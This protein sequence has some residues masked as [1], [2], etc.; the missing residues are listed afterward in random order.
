MLLKS[1]LLCAFAF[2]STVL[3]AFGVTSTSSSFVVD[4]G[5][6]NPLVITVSKSNCDITSIKYRGE[7]F[8]YSNQGSHIGSGLGSASVSSSIVSLNIAKITCTTSTLTHYYVV[9]SG[10]ATVYMATYITTEPSVG[11]LRY[12]AR[13][14][15]SKLPLEYP[16]G[17]VSTTRDSSST[18]EGSDVFVVNGQT[19]SKFYSSERFIDDNTHCVYRDNDAINVCMLIPPQSYESSSGG[20]FFRDINTNNGGDMTALYFYMNSGH[21]QTESYR[22]GL[23]GPYAMSFSRSGRPNGKTLDT[24]FFSSLGISGYVANSARGTVKGTASGVGSG[25]QGVVHWYN[26]N[27]QYWA[28]TSGNSFTSPFMKPGQYTQVLYQGEYKIASKSVSVSAGTTVTSDISASNES[29]NTILQI[30]EWDGQPK[31]FRNADKQLR[32]HP[33]DSHMSSWGPLTY[34]VGSG[35]LNDVPMALFKNVNSPFTI[36]FSLTASQTGAAT[37]RVGT[38]LSFAGARPSVTINS[39]NPSNP[40]APTKIDSRGVTRGAYRGF[41]ETYDFS[42]PSGTL[43]NGQNTITINALSGSSGDRF[44]SPNFVLDAIELF[45]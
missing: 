13:L 40:G 37:L 25:L 1:S 44:L 38:T 6:E 26:S 10:E 11:E 16:F 32:M 41:G 24:S 18:V 29:R 33:S 21:V 28:Y 9:R 12:I 42:I 2:S 17:A 22:M 20:P 39:Y 30:G 5:S 8:Q 27:A 45:K 43:V 4:A 34:T 23:H 3:A 31:S 36:K 35:S 19:R 15:S 7:E 14:Q